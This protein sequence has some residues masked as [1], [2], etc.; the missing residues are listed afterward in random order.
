M[1]RVILVEPEGAYNVGF[2]ARLCKNF[3]VNEL[4]LVRPKINIE[5]AIRF[6]AK[7]REILER[8]RI[9]NSYEEAISD[10]DLK[11]AT[12]SI[13]DNEGDVLRSS[14]KPWELVN[15]IDDKK[16]VGLIFGR[17]SVGLTRD[18]IYKADF[19]LFIPA[20]PSYPVLN[21]SH[22]VGIILYEIWKNKNSKNTIELSSEY[23]S[24]ITKYIELIV[25]NIIS[26][27]EQKEIMFTALKRTIIRGLINNNDA[28]HIVRFLRK[29]YVRLSKDQR[30][31][32][33]SE[34]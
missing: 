17:E 10:L 19:L 11:I 32:L 3:E 7:G 33:D 22:A 4:Y 5:E 25:N 8:A 28:K 23:I 27:K 31:L 20:N 9:V 13:A 21:L 24:L 14:I 18:E 29:L 12:S 16:R 34:K 15:L 30:V 1:I 6:S 2:V 26:S